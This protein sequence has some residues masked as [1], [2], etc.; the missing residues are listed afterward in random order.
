MNPLLH[1][2]LLSGTPERVANRDGY[3]QGVLALAKENERILVLTADVAESTRVLAFKEQFPKRFIECGVAEQNMMGIAAGLALSGYIPFV[4]SYAT[5]SPGRSWDQLRVSVCYS[6]ANV[7]IIGAHT[8]ISVGPDGATHQALEDIAM[9][10][11]LP[12]LVILAPCDVHEARKATIAAANYDGPVYLRLAREKTPVITTEDTPFEIGRAYVVRPGTDITIVATG[13]LLAEALFAAEAL[14]KKNID[15]E[16]INCPTVKP[17]DEATLQKSFKKTGCAVTV[18]EHQI[19]G[20]LFGV[21]SE[22]TSR[23]HPIPLEPVGMPNAFGESGEPAE[24]LATY[25]MDSVGIQA[26]VKRLLRRI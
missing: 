3:G 8:G 21:I 9:T 19:T 12:G 2:A 17:L 11:V 4:S 22:F 25:G 15:V 7:K 14:S 16:V 1:P 18:E 26:A 5:F 20:G 10:R 23:V 6:K 24:L 13:P